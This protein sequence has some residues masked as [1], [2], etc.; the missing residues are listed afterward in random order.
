MPS[1]L[2]L[3]A[4]TVLIW[5]GYFWK[6]LVYGF[7]ARRG[8]YTTSHLHELG[9]A[10]QVHLLDG[11]LIDPSSMICALEKSKVEYE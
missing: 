11:D 9:I 3:L 8:T 6:K 2:V 4:K 1:S 7:F 10:D 5:L